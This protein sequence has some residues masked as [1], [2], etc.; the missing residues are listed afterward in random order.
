MRRGTR[1]LRANPLPSASPLL[2]ASTLLS[3]SPFFNASRVR[4]A[5]LGVLASLALL[6]LPAQAAPAAFPVKP[7]RL[8]VAFG[9]GGIA[10][11]L[12]RL[13]GQRM[14]EHIGQPVVIENR[15]GAGGTVGAKIVAAAPPDGY[16]LLVHTTAIVV[17]AVASREAPDPLVQLTP[18]AATV[19]A[20]TIFV[21]PRATRQSNLLEYLRE[22]HG[23]QF[24]YSS[25]GIGTTEHLTAAYVFSGIPGL[26]GTHVPFQGGSA[27]VT[28]VA[29]G[30]VDLAATTMPTAGAYIR[31]GGVRVMAVAAHARLASL[32]EVPTLGES[33]FPT[34]ENSSWVGVFAPAG[35]PQPLLEQLNREIVHALLE[36]EV[37]ARLEGL[38]FETRAGTQAEFAGY[39]KAQVAQ[40]TQVIARTGFT[41][42]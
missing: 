30:Q 40:W 24:S 20:P 10:D 29:A 21:G 27:P 41:I 13:I 32:P 5:G 3:A 31:Q 15:S 19:S 4:T 22:A 18:V 33:G 23:G 6:A 9:A 34:F 16:T 38:G 11:T 7:I 12:A 2:R 14:S 42:Q 8:M 36:P 28:A 17:N 35:T 26:E 37:A 39:V 1:R 25:A